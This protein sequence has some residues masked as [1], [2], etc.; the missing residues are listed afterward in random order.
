MDK[1]KRLKVISKKIVKLDKERKKLISDLKDDDIEQRLFQKIYVDGKG[2]RASV[3]EVSEENY[4]N[5]GVFSVATIW[6][7]YKKLKEKLEQD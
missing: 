6:K 3:E 1:N 5:G 4:N 7:R 2:V